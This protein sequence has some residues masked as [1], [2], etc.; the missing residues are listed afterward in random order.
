MKTYKTGMLCLLSIFSAQSLADF[1]VLK[2]TQYRCMAEIRRGLVYGTGDPMSYATLHTGEVTK[3]QTWDG[4]EGSRICV[5]LAADCN[6][7][8]S[9]FFCVSSTKGLSEGQPVDGDF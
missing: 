8:S 7:F 5:R 4:P 2:S 3:D 1:P 6:N 9:S